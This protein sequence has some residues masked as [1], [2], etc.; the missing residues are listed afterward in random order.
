VSAIEFNITYI[1]ADS[2]EFVTGRML[3]VMFVLQF[4]EYQKR[5][6]K[7]IVLHQQQK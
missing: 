4:A 2:K 6:A 1:E 5:I 3:S 7:N